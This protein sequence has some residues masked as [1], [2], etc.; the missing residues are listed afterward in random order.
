MTLNYIKSF[1][2]N[3]LLKFYYLRRK[4]IMKGLVN[5]TLVSLFAFASATLIGC[6]SPSTERHHN[7]SHHHE[8]SKIHHEHGDK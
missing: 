7:K 5:L 6:C 8:H 4:F 2:I 1:L 3:M